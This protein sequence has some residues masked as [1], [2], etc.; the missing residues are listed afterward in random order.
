MVIYF[1]LEVLF[2]LIL[3]NQK[4]DVKEILRE[5]ILI[6]EDKLVIYR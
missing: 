2:I 5:L 6:L 3:I 1:H 4:K